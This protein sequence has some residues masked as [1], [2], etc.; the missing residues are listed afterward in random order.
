MSYYIII[1]GPAGVGK[2]TISELLADKVYANVAH[3]D[4][5]MDK[6]GLDYIQG[7]KWIPL[8]KFLKA[9]ATTVPEF[10]KELLNGKN[11]IFDGNFYHEEQVEDII[12][13]LD[14]PHLVFTLK[15][16]LKDCIERDTTRKNGLGEQATTDVFNLVSAFDYGIRI[17]TRNKKP[18]EIV[19]E[20][21]V[22][23]HNN[24]L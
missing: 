6:L 11:I 4:A 19:S 9:D 2:T 1:R 15:A 24:K 3:F 5:L 23:L 17:D 13:K 16:D 7:E 18:E 20:I 12:S 21:L 8:H 14:F 22:H 10:K